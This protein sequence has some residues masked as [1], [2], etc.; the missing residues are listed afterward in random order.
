MFSLA[1]DFIFEHY[2]SW[3]AGGLF[4]SALPETCLVSGIQYVLKTL[5]EKK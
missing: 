5:V 2:G 3:G 1:V 4:L